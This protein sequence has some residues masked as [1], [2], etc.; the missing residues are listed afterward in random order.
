MA[1]ETVALAE[2]VAGLRFEDL[3]ARVL[4]EAKSQ[5]LS[6]LGAVCGSASSELAAPVL[7]VVERWP[8]NPEATLLPSG[9]KVP[10]LAAIYG[11]AALSMALDYDDYLFAGHTGH[12]AVLVSLA[13]AEKLGLGGRDVLV[14]QVA[15]NEVEGRLGASVLL[16]PLNGQLW[17]FIHLA[18]GA[19]IAGRLLGLSAD[20]VASA[21]GI[22]LLQPNHGLMAGFFGAESKLL[23][24]STTATAG[25]QAAELAASGLR[26]SQEILEHPQGFVRTFSREPLFGAFGGL[27]RTWLSETLSFKI[28]PGCAYVHTLVDAILELVAGEPLDPDEV[29]RIR[30]GATPLT[31]GMDALSAPHLRGPQSSAVTLN[32][33]VPYNAAAAL[34]D[35]ELTPRQF[36][37]ERIADHRLWALADRVELALDEE[38]TEKMNEASL[39][40]AGPR[41]FELDLPSA[42]LQGFR[43]SFGARVEIE[44]RGGRKLSH[45]VEVPRGAAGRPQRE[46]RAAAI[47]KFR[48]EALP[49][50]GFERTERVLRAVLGFEELSAAGLRDLLGQFSTG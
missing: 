28:Y 14:A 37:R 26:G 45:A 27:G 7:K 32:F 43:M 1:G 2:W 16:G 34:I 17:S 10:A 4:E 39:L 48:R 47:D 13:L 29:S 23:L 35:R 36:T 11:N 24:A 19:L 44:L 21:L 41:G 46:K 15:A 38:W 18:G 33:S 22:A 49:H 30:I 20:A 8:G 40:R 6:V 3:P 50:L 12:S 25:V 9:R 5:I 42:D 31:L